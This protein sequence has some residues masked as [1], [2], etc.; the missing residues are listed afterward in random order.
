MFPGKLKQGDEIR[1]ISPSRSLELID[2][3]TQALAIS[4]LEQLGLKVTYSKNAK[5]IDE[6]KSSSILSRIEDL[7][8]AFRD[9]NVEGIITT[10]GGFNSNQLLDYID[11]D[12][13]KANPK[14]FCGLSDITAIHNAIHSKTGL[15]TYYGPH[16]SSFGMLKGI[17]YTLDYFK[18]CLFGS[19]PF[20]VSQA[21][22]WS[23]DAWLKDQENREFHTN[24][25][26]LVINEGE[27]EGKLIGGHLGTL[28][29]SLGTDYK[30]DFTDKILLI[31][32]CNTCGPSAIFMF[33][34]WLQALIHQPTFKGVKGLIIGTFQRNSGF[35]QEL[36]IKMI[37]SKKELDHIPVIANASFGHTTSRFTF[38]IGGYGKLTV[39]NEK[40]EFTIVKY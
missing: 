37:K 21:K 9:P 26:Y 34:R 12:L 24:E 17:E 31:E 39:R 28:I 20:T 19:E 15:V 35:N 32:E 30:P 33:E 36:F 27:S 22:V 18:Q 14:V 40:A 38:P 5:E 3:K 16:F 7:H 11:Y 8:D 1:V 13:I 25:G 23:D 10:S 4:R 6:F 29:L 2:E